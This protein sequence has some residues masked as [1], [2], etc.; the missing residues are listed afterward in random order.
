MGFLAAAVIGF[1]LG[2]SGHTDAEGFGALLAAC[3][4]L[5]TLHMVS[6]SPV[7]RLFIEHCRQPPSPRLA[8]AFMGVSLLC[9]STIAAIAAAWGK[10]A[11]HLWLLAQA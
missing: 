6:K 11:R 4:C 3:L 8:L 7:Y 5:T 2:V 9:N 10:L 1:T